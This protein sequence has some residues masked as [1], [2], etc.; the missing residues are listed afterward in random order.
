MD[1]RL[2]R[3]DEPQFWQS[4]KRHSPGP[5][6]HWVAGKRIRLIVGEWNGECI[7]AVFYNLTL[8]SAREMWD[9]SPRIGATSMRLRSEHEPSV[10]PLRYPGVAPARHNYA[11]AA[12]LWLRRHG[13]TSR[14]ARAYSDRRVRLGLPL[15][16]PRGTR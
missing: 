5:C 3:H 16:L 1:Q 2:K 11:A 12:A 14:C 7:D 15:G 6:W 4:L 13:A 8:R 9:T 10:S